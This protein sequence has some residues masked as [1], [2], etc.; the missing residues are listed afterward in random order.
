[1]TTATVVLFDGC[2]TPDALA[3]IDVK[4][5]KRIETAVPALW[6]RQVRVLVEE[7]GP[8]KDVA[9]DARIDAA[10]A[11]AAAL[12]A[13]NKERRGTKCTSTTRREMFWC[14]LC[15]ANPVNPHAGEDTCHSCLRHG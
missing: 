1:M 8:R 10:E 12:R 11:A 3:G 7:I 2:L 5:I 13:H 4:A 9:L 14:T 6:G 15:G